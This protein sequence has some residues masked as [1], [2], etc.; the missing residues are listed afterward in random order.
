MWRNQTKRNNLRYNWIHECGQFSGGFC[1]QVKLRPVLYA[2]TSAP[3][4][5]KFYHYFLRCSTFHS[6]SY[7]QNSYVEALKFERGQEIL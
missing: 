2:L 3:L 6:E 5:K 7:S 4:Y 1:V